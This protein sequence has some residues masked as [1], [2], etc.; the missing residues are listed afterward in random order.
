MTLFVVVMAA[1][2]VLLYFKVFRSKLRFA[3]EKSRDS[4]IGM[5]KAVNQSLQQNFS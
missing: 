5:T 1:V 3:G 4:Q 2:C